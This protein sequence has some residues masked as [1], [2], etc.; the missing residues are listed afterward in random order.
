MILNSFSD[1]LR[2]AQRIKGYLHKSMSGFLVMHSHSV[3]DYVF[4]L[5]C[6]PLSSSILSSVLL[7]L[8]GLPSRWCILVTCLGFFFTVNTFLIN[9]LPIF[10]P[11]G[12][13]NKVGLLLMNSRPR[14]GTPPLAVFYPTNATPSSSGIPYVP[15]L[16]KRFLQGMATYAKL[17][18]FLVKDI[19][20]VRLYAILGATP[21]P[22]L[23]SRQPAPPIVVFSHGLAGFHTFYSCLAMDLA[24]RGA[25]VVCIGHSD[26]SASFMR[27]ESG[28]GEEIPFKVLKMDASDREPQLAQRI[29]E[30][31]QVLKYVAEADFWTALGYPKEDVMPFIARPFG[32][33]LAGHSFGGATVLATALQ[34][35]QEESGTN[36][37]TVFTFD[38]WMLPLQN[39]YF[40][41]PIVEEGKK[42][43]I[44]T[45]SLHS[46]Q[47]ARDT[48]SWE[49]FRRV[50]V[51]VTS[52]PCHAM[53]S[54]SEKSAFFVTEKKGG[55]N[56]QSFTDLCL[57]SPV[58]HGCRSSMEPPRVR[59]MEFS[60]A[61]LRFAKEHTTR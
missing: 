34:E 61:L 19:I 57:L 7:H 32:V 30:T 4:S 59:I 21:A 44:P 1:M 60:N 50:S 36:V 51:A 45:H 24:A 26:G 17:P 3:P 43:T 31:R 9:P 52:H 16:D 15:F 27:E 49:F 8:Y 12:G 40:Y 33:H 58:F 47:W 11:L 5:H 54:E 25:V 46:E 38:P 10:S 13:H 2:W 29:A 23:S 6:F 35:S 18:Y 42:Y 48:S 37:K 39:A 22:V 53:L 41:N 14:R 28:H 55:T 20:F 56:H